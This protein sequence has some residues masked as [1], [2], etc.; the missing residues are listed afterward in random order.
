MVHVFV[1][2]RAAS[3]SYATQL[4]DIPARPQRSAS[5][6]SPA[7]KASARG[8]ETGRAVSIDLFKERKTDV[9]YA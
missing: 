9:D 6:Q 8:E 3:L 4:D 5:R 7:M 1:V 2:L